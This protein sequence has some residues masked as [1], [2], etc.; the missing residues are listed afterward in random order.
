M[1]VL[2]SGIFGT[3]WFHTRRPWAGC[4]ALN[5]S[6]SC[7]SGAIMWLNA[8]SSQWAGQTDL[9][10]KGLWAVQYSR[11]VKNSTLDHFFHWKRLNV[12]V[13]SG[14]GFNWSSTIKE[15]FKGVWLKW[16]WRAKTFR[17]FPRTDLSWKDN[18][19]LTFRWGKSNIFLQAET[20]SFITSAIFIFP[21]THTKQVWRRSASTFE[22][23]LEGDKQTIRG[24][25]SWIQVDT[26]QC[27]GC[28]KSEL[29]CTGD[30]PTVTIAGA[31]VHVLFLAFTLHWY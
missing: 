7:I 25:F 28:M 5:G 26:R 24:D 17:G 31:R 16:S 4:R 6:G 13:K 8:Y 9:Q 1:F 23:D 18:T 29:F 14:C 2:L 30:A 12:S 11:F 27:R 3:G 19:V 20:H 21:S 10:C 15:L 22:S